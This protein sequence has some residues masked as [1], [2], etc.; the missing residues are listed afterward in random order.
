MVDDIDLY[1]FLRV[2]GHTDD[3]AVAVVVVVFV[4]DHDESVYE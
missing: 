1:C 4:V 3:F 2:A